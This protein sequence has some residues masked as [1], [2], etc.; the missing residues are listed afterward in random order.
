MREKFGL[1]QW[2]ER[3][4]KLRT[5]ML[6]HTPC[7]ACGGTGVEKP[8]VKRGDIVK[9]LYGGRP[10]LGVVASLGVILLTPSDVRGR[11]TTGLVDQR[12]VHGYLHIDRDDPTP[13]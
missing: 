2:A 8:A 12:V 7:A 4:R 3:Y 10:A 11:Y 9:G 5:Q 13:V 6:N 1:K